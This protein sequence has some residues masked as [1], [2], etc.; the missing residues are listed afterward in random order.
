[1][2]LIIRP[3]KATTVILDCLFHKGYVFNIDSQN[4]Q[5]KD[6]NKMIQ[7]SH[8]GK[9]INYDSKFKFFRLKQTCKKI[10]RFT[11]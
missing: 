6:F 2:A 1:M 7:E 9:L 5:V 10:R 3:L 11:S 8:K 4:Y